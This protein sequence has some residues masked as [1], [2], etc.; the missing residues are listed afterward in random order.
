MKVKV[1]DIFRHFLPGKQLT[2]TTPVTLIIKEQESLSRQ[3][4]SNVD[5]STSSRTHCKF[6]T[7][8]DVLGKQNV[9]DL[10]KL[11]TTL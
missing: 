8:E 5:P 2:E 11:I 1:T 6:I 3:S 7:R 10:P 9:K 4:F